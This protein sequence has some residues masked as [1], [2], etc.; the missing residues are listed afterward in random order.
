M[1]KIKVKIHRCS[2]KKQYLHITQPYNYC[3]YCGENLNE[4]NNEPN[5]EKG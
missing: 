2:V 5:E 4:P 1:K 3:P